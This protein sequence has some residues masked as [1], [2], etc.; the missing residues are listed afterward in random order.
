MSRHPLDPVS[1]VLGLVVLAA[2]VAAV[3]G[4][5]GE[6]LNQ[7]AAAVP[8]AIALVGIALILSVR[9][10]APPDEELSG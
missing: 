5:L 6:L 1:L 9:R 2:G 7:P 3:M 10:S 4:E 8:L